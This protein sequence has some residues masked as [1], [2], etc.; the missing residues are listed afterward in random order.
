MKTVPALAPPACLAL[1][2][3]S[4]PAAAPEPPAVREARG[5]GSWV[6][7]SNASSMILLRAM[8]RF[9]PE[10]A[11]SLGL[12]GCDEGVIDLRPGHEE[13]ARAALEDAVAALERRQA[14]ERDLAVLQDVDI[15]LRAARHALEEQALRRKLLLPY[16]DV[17]SHV[18]D[19]LRGLL[20]EQVA[21]ER[22]AAALV[23]LRRYA[24]LEQGYEPIAK[25]AEE[26]TRERLAEPGLAG[27]ARAEVERDLENL[28]AMARGIEEH[29][30]KHDLRG[31]EE[32]LRA[33]RSQL[34]AYSRF[35]GAEVLPRSRTDFR[36][37]PSIYALALRAAGVDMGVEE[38]QGRAKAAFRETQTDMQAL[39]PLVAREKG[40][41][42][43]DYR[44]VI[45]AL[46]ERQ[47][48]GEA[49]LPHYRQRL[50]DLERLIVANRLVSLP[51]RPLHARLATEAESALFP[52]PYM[53]PPPLLG[54]TGERGTLVLPRHVP[55]RGQ[56]DDY[57]YEAASWT[58]TAHEGRPGHELQFD[59][60]LERGVST[61]R[62]LF[63]Y[64]SVNVE[65]WALYAEAE[66][67]PHEPLEGQLV[68]LQFRLL[69]AARAFLDPGLQSGAT[70]PEE[71]RRLLVDDVV[72][73]RASADQEIERYTFR[74]PGQA[75][76]YFCGYQRLLELRTDV[77]RVLGRRFDRQ[78]YHDFILGQG[79]LPPSLLRKAVMEQ[80]VP[81]E[82]EGR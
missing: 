13:R 44:D 68:A 15:L 48:S 49:I 64:N 61:A 73:S 76:S 82:R 57:S 27:P 70:T 33:L 26:R 5:T 69:R 24:G 36:L 77:E 71:A 50:A 62:A 60:M 67:R 59:S 72:M 14:A 66:A 18:F 31:W 23:R 3:L 37:P 63:A 29:F 58:I 4:A 80:F 42:A 35:V 17:A 43:T 30:R 81:A 7:R 78:R 47:L 6:E 40:W 53:L 79:L 51:E 38:L 32:P 39:A 74:D 75:A 16:Y 10:Q 20:D 56:P 12:S 46:K 21:P 8:A 34:E 52:G 1:A 9:V 45:R 25:L 19:G 11:G 2:L 55:D 28:P 41:A 65:G 22:R 54:N